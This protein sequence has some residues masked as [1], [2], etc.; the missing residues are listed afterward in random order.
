MPDT[1]DSKSPKGNLVKVSR[2]F[3][4]PESSRPQ[5]RAKR[6]HADDGHAYHDA[7]MEEAETSLSKDLTKNVGIQKHLPSH[8]EE[9]HQ[10]FQVCS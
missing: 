7:A 5:K 3:S 1:A 8:A 10:K 2:F 4:E 9:L 6:G